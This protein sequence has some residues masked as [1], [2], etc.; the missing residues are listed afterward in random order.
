M[1]VVIAWDVIKYILWVGVW[2]M[3]IVYMYTYLIGVGMRFF[4]RWHIYS[5]GC[6]LRLTDR[7]TVLTYDVKD[8]C[9]VCFFIREQLF[10]VQLNPL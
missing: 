3:N 9:N 4:R 10:I 2:V 8:G 5:S 7:N 6:F 1:D